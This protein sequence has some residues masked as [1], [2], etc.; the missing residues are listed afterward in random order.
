MKTPTICPKCH[1][2][3]VNTALKLRSGTIVWKK[4]C[5][6][7]LDHEFLCIV[8]DEDN[9]VILTGMVLNRNTSLKV[10]WDFINNKIV[11][12]KGETIRFPFRGKGILEIPWFEPNMDEY[13]KL[14]NKVRKLITFS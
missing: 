5:K 1:E 9:V 13:D 3:L 6:D 4:A 10:C 7:K 14:I 2:P 12:H 8:K 11:I